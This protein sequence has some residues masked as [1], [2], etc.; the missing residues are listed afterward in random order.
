LRVPTDIPV[1]FDN[2]ASLRERRR[3]E[4]RERQMQCT[5]KLRAIRISGTLRALTLIA[6]AAL[7]FNVTPALAQRGHTV[8]A[9]GRPCVSMTPEEVD[10]R[11]SPTDLPVHVQNTCS[12][13]L[14]ADY[15]AHGRHVRRELAPNST[16]EILFPMDETQ[17]RVTI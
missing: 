5:W 17:L 9:N 8:D 12:R 3:A 11:G 7:L 14:F 6:L 13:A 2:T 4:G 10:S 15:D 16:T 1:S